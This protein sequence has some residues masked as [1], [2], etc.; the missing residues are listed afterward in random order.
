MNISAEQYNKLRLESIRT[1]KPIAELLKQYAPRPCVNNNTNNVPKQKKRNKHDE[2]DLQR[3]CVGWFRENYEDI[4]M[5]LF[6]PNNEPYFGG[7]D[8]TEKQR[9]ISGYLAKT[10][11]VTPGVADLILL[12]PSYDGLYHGL[13]IEMKWDSGGQ[14]DNQ[15]AWQ[16]AVEAKGFRYEVVKSD[17]AFRQIIREH[18]HREPKEDMTR[19][20][21][22]I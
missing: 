10:I 20:I 2:T 19:H 5:L 11:G 14:S 9:R 21:L 6:H 1:G 18:L 15:K 4:A 16:Q 12:H 17:T 7:K 22:G 13:C 3:I 8:K